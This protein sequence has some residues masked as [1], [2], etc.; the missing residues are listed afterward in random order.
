MGDR[1]PGALIFPSVDGIYGQV[2]ALPAG[3]PAVQATTGLVVTYA[4]YTSPLGAS[5]MTGSRIFANA[6]CY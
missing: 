1:R 5:P 3:N 6:V 4:D 2:S